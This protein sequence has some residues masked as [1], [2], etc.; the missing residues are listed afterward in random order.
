[1]KS[2]ILFL[3]LILVAAFVFSDDVTLLPGDRTITAGSIGASSITL[4]DNYDWTG[5]NTH[6][7]KESFVRVIHTP[8]PLTIADSGNGS[9]A[10]STLTSPISAEYRYTCSDTD[11]CN[12]TLGETGVVDGQQLCIENVSANVLNLA[13]TSGV[14]ETNGAFAAGQYDMICYTYESDRWVEKSRSN[15]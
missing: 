2:F 14:S 6:A 4:N 5:D 10:T 7:G 9:P 12:L 13:D 11:G 1:M 8:A 15:N 3:A